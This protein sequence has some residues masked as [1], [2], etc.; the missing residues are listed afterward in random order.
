MLF[1]GQTVPRD[2]PERIRLAQLETG[3]APNGV[4]QSRVRFGDEAEDWG[5][6]NGPCHDCAVVKG[7]Y[8]VPGCDVERCPTCGGQ[9]Y[10]CECDWPELDE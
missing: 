5:A 4:P 10:A 9:I 3:C 1:R 7:E 8:H 2:W 6:E